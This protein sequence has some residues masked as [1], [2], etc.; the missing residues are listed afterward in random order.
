MPNCSQLWFR[1]RQGVATPRNERVGTSEQPYAAHRR[2]SPCHLRHS[3]GKQRRISVL[4]ISQSHRVK[5]TSLFV[6]GSEVPSRRSI[7]RV[8]AD[9]SAGH[10]VRDI[11]TAGDFHVGGDFNDYSVNEGIL[12]RDLSDDGLDIEWVHRSGNLAAFSRDRHKKLGVV[13]GFGAVLIAL[14]VAFYV[15]NDGVDLSSVLSGLSSAATV[16]FAVANW[17]ARSADELRQ[18]DALEEIRQLRID[19]RKRRKAVSPHV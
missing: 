2:S 17:G 18:L 3:A 1:E 9:T 14:T 13:I 6:S 10:M 12:I 7:P 15:R 8:S 19:R 4:G 5:P 16:Y 11:N